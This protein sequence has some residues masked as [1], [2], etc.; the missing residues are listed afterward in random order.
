V[1]GCEGDRFGSK[2]N[3]IKG[4][5]TMSKREAYEQKLEAQLK[6]W[7]I[8]IDK[9][10]AKADKADAQARLEYYKKIEELRTKQEAAQKKLTELK[11][12]GEDAW[13]DLKAGIDLAWGSLGE[14]V[15]SARS[16][17]K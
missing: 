1:N 7:K 15:K 5:K 17:F 4:E 14:A 10:K 3:T 11:A 9:M 12:A 2:N 13:E 8:D 6:E 16:R